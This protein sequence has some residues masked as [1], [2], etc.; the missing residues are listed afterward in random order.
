MKKNLLIIALTVALA[1]CT[2]PT[3]TIDKVEDAVVPTQFDPLLNGRLAEL[4]VL[5]LEAMDE[6]GKPSMVFNVTELD[7]KAAIIN[8]GTKYAYVEL[9]G[10]TNIISKNYHEMFKMYKQQEVPGVTYCKTKL[11][12][13]AA[14]IERALDIVGQKTK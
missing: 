8:A 5:T 3:K 14:N 9:A 12:I 2:L 7:R 13:N 4:S 6:C 1:G 11:R 10:L